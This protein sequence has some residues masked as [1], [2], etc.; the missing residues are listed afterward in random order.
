MLHCFLWKTPT[1][2]I[3]WVT[4]AWINLDESEVASGPQDSPLSPLSAFAAASAFPAAQWAQIMP[5]CLVITN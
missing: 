4:K 2:M 3:G 5:L 1:L